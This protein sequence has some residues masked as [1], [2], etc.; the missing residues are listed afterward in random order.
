MLRNKVYNNNNEPT[1]LL[2]FLAARSALEEILRF[3]VAVRGLTPLYEAVIA[4]NRVD[5]S[6]RSLHAEGCDLSVTAAQQ[7]THAAGVPHSHWWWRLE[8]PA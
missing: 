2:R 6:L 4:L 8:A 1:L 7:I 5:T 3:R